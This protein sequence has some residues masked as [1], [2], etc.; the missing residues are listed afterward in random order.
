MWDLSNPWGGFLELQ[1]THPLPAKRILQLNETAEELGLVPAY[2][3]VGQVRPPESL[4]DEFIVD[5]F[6]QYVAFWLLIL[7]PLIGGVVFTMYDLNFFVGAGVGL[8]AASFIWWLRVRMKYPKVSFKSTPL[9]TISDTIR[10]EYEASPVRGKPAH[11]EGQIIGRGSPGY[12]FSEDLVLQ[13]ETGIITLDYENPIGFNLLY[14]LF[15]VP[16]TIGQKARVVGWF[17]RTPRPILVIHK[18]EVQNV[19]DTRSFW[20]FTRYFAL[21]FIIGVAIYLIALGYGIV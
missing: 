17:K 1:S 14:S 11:F 3:K 5:I 12:Y 15:K 8:L 7:F 18:M 21:F 9:R 19:G 16:R 13:D 10:Q 6:L 4:W 2:P 20:R